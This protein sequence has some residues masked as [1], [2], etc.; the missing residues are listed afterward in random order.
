M[1]RFQRTGSSTG[2]WDVLCGSTTT[3]DFTIYDNENSKRAIQIDKLTGVGSNPAL[4][5]DSSGNVDVTGTV[6]ADN[7][8]H[9]GLV[10]VQVILGT[11]TWT[12][13]SGISKVRVYV[14]AGGGSGGGGGA[15]QD[16]GA[17]GG[18]GGTAI[19]LVDVRSISSVSCTV[20]GG[21]AAKTSGSTNGNTGGATSFGSHC[22]ASGGVG[23]TY[24]N[25]G[26]VVGGSGGVGSGGD[27]NLYGGYGSNGWDNFT[28]L[29]YTWSSG[30][31]Q[32]GA[33]YWGGGGSGNYGG[34]QSPQNGPSPN[35]Y[36]AGGG[37]AM[38]TTSLTHGN[39]G[40]GYQGCIIVEEYA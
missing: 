24:G 8:H 1:A 22:S 5:I 32:G 30:L 3:G 14:T 27:I 15:N 12:K 4:K 6:T 33:S 13:P 34:G 16:F 19:K 40:P 31:S 26:P 2:S 11:G 29:T 17:G 21:G 7:W 9:V 20:G 10:S 37:G 38:H 39:S 36:G 35:V 18:A 23:G 25:A 28:G